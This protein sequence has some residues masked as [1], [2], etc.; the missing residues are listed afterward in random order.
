MSACLIKI[1]DR[2][3]RSEQE[4]SDLLRKGI[5]TFSKRHLEAYLLDDSIIQKLCTTSNQPDKYEECIAKKQQALGNIVSQGKPADDIK[6][7]RG[8]IYLGLKQTLGLLHCGNSADAFIRDT[9]APLVTED[10]EI[11]RLLETDIW[12]NN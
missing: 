2:D 8:E 4:I 12:G 7:A 5:K 6:S 10:T 9:M 11:F 1:V 3:D